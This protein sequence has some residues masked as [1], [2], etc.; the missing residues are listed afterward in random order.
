MSIKWNRD[1]E[2]QL[3]RA[4]QPELKEFARKNQ[5]RMDEFKRKYKGR[6]VDEI[7]RALQREIKSW[8]G[9]APDRAELTQWATAISRGERVILKPAK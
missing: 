8:G 6:P 9:S 2:K 4:A 5:P 1:F 7:E 3:L